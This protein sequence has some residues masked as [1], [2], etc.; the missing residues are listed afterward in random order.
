VAVAPALALAMMLSVAVTSPALAANDTTSTTG[1]EEA[2]SDPSGYRVPT[3]EELAA[4]REEAA[5]LAAEVTDQEKAVAEAQAKVNE[6]AFTLQEARDAEAAAVATETAAR[7]EEKAQNER[8]N[9]AQALVEDR[10]DEMGQ[11]A[12]QT[13]RTGG[14]MGTV[15]NMMILLES[16]NTDDMAQRMQMLQLVGR[17]RGSVVDTV[18]EAEAVQADA[19]ARAA[20]ASAQ[21][22][23]AHADAATARLAAEDAFSQQTTQLLLIT[24]LLNKT[25]SEAIAASADSSAMAAKMLGSVPVGQ[26][27]PSNRITGPVDPNCPGGDISIY[28]NGQI[29]ES[30]L[31]PLIGAPGHLLR[32]DA[33]YAFNQMSLA[34]AA[35]FGA[36]ICVTD[37]YRDLA[38]QIAS[39]PPSRDWP[40]ARAPVGTA[41]A[42]PWTCAVAFRASAPRST[43]GCSSTPPS[44]GGTTRCGPGPTAASPSRGTS[45]TRTGCTERP[46]RPAS[47]PR[48]RGAVR[49]GAPWLRPARRGEHHPGVSGGSRPGGALPRNRRARHRRRTP[50]GLP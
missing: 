16:E 24:T 39:R 26:P 49:D 5:K 22:V 25:R 1:S 12:S 28:P 15:E 13:Y 47:L 32:A 30:L 20:A 29:P 4:K 42:G 14:S 9:A 19:A 6:L 2:P 3:P 36:P 31:C 40:P 48:H 11:W 33:A 43:S 23:A 18:E 7:A 45:S 34:Y 27:D 44:T 46:G 41:W 8:L 50:G 10:K 37:S 17:W 35:E 38:G 21:A